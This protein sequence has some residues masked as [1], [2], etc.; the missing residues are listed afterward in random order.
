MEVKKA[1]FAR[2]KDAKGRLGI[3]CCIG[4]IHLTIEVHNPVL[5]GQ[6]LSLSAVASGALWPAL[7]AQAQA[8]ASAFPNRPMRYI[9]PVAAGG[10]SDLVGRTVTER[11]G[12][13]IQAAG[14]SMD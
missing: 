13:V 3:I 1:L 9:V 11:W 12:K 6:F 10:G 2:A 7:S 4:L 5:G 8:Q 14:I